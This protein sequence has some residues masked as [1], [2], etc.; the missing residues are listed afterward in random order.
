MKL[1]AAL[2]LAGEA[3]LN[4][5]YPPHC[6]S[7]LADTPSGIHLCEKCAE[8]APAIKAPFCRQCSVCLCRH[9]IDN[10]PN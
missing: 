6:A 10:A 2:R 7:C 8:Q 9:Q 3:F 1:T 5:L 4:A